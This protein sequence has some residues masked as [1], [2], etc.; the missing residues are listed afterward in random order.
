MAVE[1]P[2]LI[3]ILNIAEWRP[4]S[5]SPKAEEFLSNLS[6]KEQ[7]QLMN[8]FALYLLRLYQSMIQHAIEAQ[9]FRTPDGTL[10]MT[11]QP[12]SS[13]W[14]KKKRQMGLRPGFWEATGKIQKS[15][16]YW[17]RADGSYVIGFRPQ[18]R[19]PLSGQRVDVI[20][21]TL[22]RGYLPRNLPPRPLFIPIARAIN[23]DIYNHFQ[24]FIKLKYP[25]LKNLFIEK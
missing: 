3:R 25:Q 18:T 19:H 20:A 4:L 7:D 10:G 11:F 23:K 1:E 14:R 9:S 15:I 24:R 16:T 17:R 8:D 12:L 5:K 13:K 6:E 22:E 21:R 2:I